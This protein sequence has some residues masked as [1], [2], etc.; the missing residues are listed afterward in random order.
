MTQERIQ[1][2]TRKQQREEEAAAKEP[3]N[4]VDADKL[5]NDLDTLIDEIDA[6]L[7]SEAEAFVKSYV[8]KGGE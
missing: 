4:H 1:K 8:Q 3:T 6:V 7:E 2:K 5:K